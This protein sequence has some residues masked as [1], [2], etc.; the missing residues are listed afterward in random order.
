LDLTD[1]GAHGLRRLTA[2]PEVRVL[3]VGGLDVGDVAT[4]LSAMDERDPEETSRD[5]VRLW[6][7]QA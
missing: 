3:P 1:T 2:L 4:A 5:A 7:A 6:G